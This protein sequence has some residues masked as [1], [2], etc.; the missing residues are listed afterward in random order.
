MHNDDAFFSPPIS[1]S[2]CSASVF[3]SDNTQAQNEQNPFAQNMDKQD[4]P[5]TE[6]GRE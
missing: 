3:K 4:T 2:I 1:P 6:S 5:A